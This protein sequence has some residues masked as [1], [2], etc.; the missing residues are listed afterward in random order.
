MNDETLNLTTENSRTSA[1]PISVPNSAPSAFIIH[2]SS[3]SVPSGF[4]IH[5]S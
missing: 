1:P 3:F 4:I 5:P 2:P